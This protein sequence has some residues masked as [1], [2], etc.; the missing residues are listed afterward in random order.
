MGR[1]PVLLL[2][3]HRTLFESAVICEYLDEVTPG[4][5]HPSDNLE[6]SY[7]RAWIEF[8]SGILQGIASL[9]NAKDSVSFHKIHE[10]IQSKFRLVEKEVSGSPFFSGKKFHLIDAVYGP[11]FRY[12]EVFDIYINLN[13]FEELPKCQVWRKA[14]MQRKSVQKAVSENY[15]ALLKQFLRAKNT[16][17]S[18]LLL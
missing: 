15:P 13:T 4:S 6:K 10:D 11:I 9:Y 8:G 12:F 1:V 18:Q 14:L 17:I 5:L 2:K 7:H 16:Y 3:E